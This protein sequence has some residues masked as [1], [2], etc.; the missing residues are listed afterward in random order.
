MKKI[1]QNQR[2]LEEKQER[3][4]KQVTQETASEP[5]KIPETQKE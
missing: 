4:R 2:K 5:G 3:P 1:I